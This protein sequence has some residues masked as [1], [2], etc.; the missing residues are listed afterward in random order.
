MSNNKKI[1]VID[2]EPDVVKMVERVLILEDYDVT[3]ST[4]AEQAISKL[5]DTPFDLVITDIRMP[6]MN[7]L[8]VIQ[9]VKAF[10]PTI[11]IIV[12]SGYATMEN[13]VEALKEGGAFH[14]VM[15]PLNDIDS[16][17]HVITQALEKRQL[18]IDNK[19]LMHKLITVNQD[20]E[21][22]VKQKTARLE[23]RVKELEVTKQELTVALEK[24]DAARQA[25]SEFL[26]IMSHELKTP[27][28]IIMGNIDLLSLKKPDNDTKECIDV[29][30]R[31]CLS[32]SDIVDD[33]LLFSG[34]DY[35]NNDSLAEHFNISEVIAGIEQILMQRAKEKN[36][37]F[38]IDV[39]PVIPFNLQGKWRLIRQIVYNLCGNAIKFTNQGECRLAIKQLCHS[40]Q[41]QKITN[42]L[43]TLLF[44]VSDTGIGISESIKDKIFDFFTQGDQSLTRSYGGIGMGL[45][46]CKKLADILNGKLWF[47]SKENE[48]SQFFF[49]LE[50]MSKKEELIFR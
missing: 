15:K 34:I 28:N 31:T 11:E 3:T 16:F 23:D 14:F 20:L 32:F 36:L 43:I 38:K 26:G 33:L 1:L 13:A 25:K 4:D 7:G 24:A 17:Y 40:G 46:I 45:A 42:G 9:H 47:E 18:L 41:T 19:K 39:D 21:E 8:E 49:Q 37:S 2:D 44:E 48:G 12:L 27:I 30:K 6:G 29:V 22:Q 50:V 5:H 35:N 10:D